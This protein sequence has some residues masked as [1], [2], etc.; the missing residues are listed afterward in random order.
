MRAGSDGSVFDNDAVSSF[1]DSA[2][3]AIYGRNGL[4]SGADAVSIL[5][6]CF[7]KQTANNTSNVFPFRLLL[8]KGRP[9]IVG[10]V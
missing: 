1:F 4:F 2:S 6:H 10:N 8:V 5:M 3:L 7:H 9:F